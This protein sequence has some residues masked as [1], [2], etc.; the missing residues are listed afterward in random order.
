M[1]ILEKNVFKGF[2][3][4]TFSLGFVVILPTRVFDIVGLAVGLLLLFLLS[5]ISVSKQGFLCWLFFLCYFLI[6]TILPRQDP[7]IE[8]LYWCLYVIR[9]FFILFIVQCFF[10]ERSDFTFFVRWLQFSIG[11]IFLI[12]ILKIV[13]VEIFESRIYDDMYRL[14]GFGNPN[15][16]SF[17]A[18]VL[19]CVNMGEV[20]ISTK[21]KNFQD[22]KHR[23]SII[24]ALFV[25]LP[26][27]FWTGSRGGLLAL[28]I[29]FCLATAILLKRL[30]TLMPTRYSV[31]VFSRVCLIILSI[32]LLYFSF[33]D[34]ADELLRV[35]DLLSGGG[36]G[37]DVIWAKALELIPN[38]F[39]ALIG[40]GGGITWT[41]LG[42]ELGGRIGFGGTHNDY[43][44]LLVDYGIMG[45]AVFLMFNCYLSFLLYKSNRLGL[46][47]SHMFTMI[48]SLSNDIVNGAPYAILIGFYLASLRWKKN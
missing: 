43:I 28:L 8:Q 46:F 15:Y 47:F 5:R 9:F 20:L 25:L 21:G 6:L 40:L 38:N 11:F 16:L 4:A 19:F 31:R 2:A 27:M 45:L 30:S 10:S 24:Y 41:Y 39:L 18:G 44:W 36:S 37:R 35:E 3:L 14:E 32:A 48:F 17:A 1:L 34:F 7:N 13:G 23:L 26:V 42:M 12:A 29:V 33:A 22:L